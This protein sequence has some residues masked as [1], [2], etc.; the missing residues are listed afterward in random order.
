MIMALVCIKKYR[1]ILYTFVLFTL[2]GCNNNASYKFPEFK[3]IDNIRG[4]TIIKDILCTNIWRMEVIDSLL[5]L[6]C[7]NSIDKKEFYIYNHISG[8]LLATFGESGNG[9]GELPANF[10]MSIDQKNR[11]IYAIGAHKNISYSIDSILTN[12][13]SYQYNK[14]IPLNDIKNSK[15]TCYL[16]NNTFYSIGD[17]RKHRDY[18]V[19]ILNEVGDTLC[20]YKEKPVL[21]E[22]D[23]SDSKYRNLFYTYKFAGTLKPDATK[24]AYATTCGLH[25]EIF[26]MEN[27]NIKRESFHKYIQPKYLKQNPIINDGV[28]EGCT[29]LFSSNNYIY[30]KWSEDTQ[31]KQATQ[32]AVF[33]WKGSSK[34]MLN[35]GCPIGV[36][37]TTPNDE[38]LFLEIK[39]E[40]GQINI[41]RYKL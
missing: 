2:Q 30:A 11:M 34:F 28:I 36:V 15:R 33:D 20:C 6:N 37:A 32:I 27:Q 3:K 19:A 14:E 7:V 31:N 22:I 9:P 25:L 39:D 16:E 23:K 35:I 1:I 18:R 41:V 40:L 8:A 29:Y 10:D 13:S 38:S 24:Y 17:F 26:S 21:T 12:K 4:D 5:V